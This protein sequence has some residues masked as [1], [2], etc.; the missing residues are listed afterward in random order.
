M[1]SKTH[2]LQIRVTAR[3]KAKLKRLAAAARQDV[4][5]YVL[6]RV[7]PSAQGRFEELLALLGEG[8]EHRYALAELNGLLCALA[9]DELREAVAHANIAHLSP[10]LKN[11]VA[12]MVDQASSQKGVRPPAWTRRVE[13]L[14]A[15][16]FAA[17]LKSLRLHLLRASPVAFKRRNLFVDAAVGA[18][19]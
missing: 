11:Y 13:P 10:F 17:P 4:S 19:V 6:S 7:L 18:R 9:R 12:A 16:Y 1:A 14:E 15:P 3:Q 5:S 8:A 2:Q